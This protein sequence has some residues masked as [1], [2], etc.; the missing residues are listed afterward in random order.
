MRLLLDTTILIDYFSRREPFFDDCVQ[1][2]AMQVFGDAELWVSAKSFTDVF[3]VL[4][5]P[6]GYEKVQRMF[7]ESADFLKVCSIDSADI[8]KASSSKWADFEDCL[9]HVCAEKIKADF[10]ITRDRE[11]FSRASIPV[12]SP[13]EFLMWVEKSKGL[14]YEEVSLA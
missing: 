7:T 6:L 8:M 5:K 13:A 2:R 4:Q 9:V 14:V 12:K 10:L 11:G 3:Y 1:L